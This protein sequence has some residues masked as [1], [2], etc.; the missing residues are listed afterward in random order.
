L[1]DPYQLLQGNGKQGA[2]VRLK[3]RN[4]LQLPA[5]RKIIAEALKH[6]RSDFSAHTKGKTN[7]EVDFSKNSARD[8]R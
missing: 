3:D 6:S 5:V 8:D 4:T 7:R 2:F 1:P